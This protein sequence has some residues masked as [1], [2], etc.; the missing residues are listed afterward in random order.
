MAREPREVLVTHL[1]QDGWTAGNTYGQ[2]PYISFGWFDDSKDRPQ[3]TIDQAKEGP[4]FRGVTPFDGFAPNGSG[5]LSQTVTGV[6]QAHC[7]AEARKLGSATTDNPRQYLG[8]AVEE[9]NRIIDANQVKPTNPSTGNQPVRLL[10]A[11]Q[12]TPVSEPDHSA[13]FHYRVTVSYL[14]STA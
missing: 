5:D 2:T 7:W 3:V 8:D 1:L 13:R 12:A 4:E 6:V 9:I 14:Y 10:A 11:H